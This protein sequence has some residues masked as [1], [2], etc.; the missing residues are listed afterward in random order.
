MLGTGLRAQSHFFD[1]SSAVEAHARLAHCAG[2]Q[3]EE[4]CTT[5][6]LQHRD[7]CMLICTARQQNAN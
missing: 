3:S 1:R 7:I 5:L 4:G 6:R 2:L